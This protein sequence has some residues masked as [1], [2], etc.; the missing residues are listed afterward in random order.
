MDIRLNQF[1]I[2]PRELEELLP[3]QLLMLQTAAQVLDRAYLSDSLRERTGVFIGLALDLNTTQFSLRWSLEPF[4]QE[5]ATRQGPC[6]RYG[7]IPQ[8]GRVPCATPLRQRLNANRTVGALGSIAASRIARE[9]HLGGPSFTVSSE[10]T[11][12]LNALETAVRALQRGDI[13]LAV[14]GAVDLAGDVRAVLG[15]GDRSTTGRRGCGGVFAQT[16]GGCRA[17]WRLDLCYHPGDWHC[18]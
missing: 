10:E 2:P 8:L 13:D 11:A 1:R 6:P 15:S 9:Y 17:R 5:W 16:S 18:I 4:L 12:G 7:G 3:Q 14:V